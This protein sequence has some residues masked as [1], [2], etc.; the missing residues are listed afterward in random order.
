[1][2]GT[3]A[4]CFYHK[5]K[6][7]YIC[8][9]FSCLCFSFHSASLTKQQKQTWELDG[10][11][12]EGENV[13][14]AVLD[15]CSYCDLIL[16]AHCWTMM[17]TM[18]G[19][20]VIHCWSGKIAQRVPVGVTLALLPKVIFKIHHFCIWCFIPFLP[21]PPIPVGVDVQVESLDTISEVDMV[22]LNSLLVKI[23]KFCFNR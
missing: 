19:G 5:K 7:V 21:G 6:V 14:P 17:T 3:Q 22:R 23:S 4:F 8:N 10:F 13:T 11:H 2:K 16:L 1:M 9:S 12:F 18:P 15:C 20:D